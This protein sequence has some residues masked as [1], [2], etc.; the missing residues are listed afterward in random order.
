MLGLPVSGA[1]RAEETSD[2][3]AKVQAKAEKAGDAAKK[4]KKEAEKA[5]KKAKKE[6]E[7]A[8][9]KAK[10]EAERTAKKAGL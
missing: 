2:L 3:V 4:E 5:A 9:K 8:A 1:L 7:K 6:A 10:K